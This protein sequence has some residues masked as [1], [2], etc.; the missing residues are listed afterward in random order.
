MVPC[1]GS[2]SASRSFR[3]AA[4]RGLP[5]LPLRPRVAVAHCPSSPSESSE[6]LQSRPRPRPR[7]RRC[8]C[9]SGSGSGSAPYEYS[10]SLSS[11]SHTNA[12]SSSIVTRPSLSRSIALKTAH[13]SRSFLESG[14][15][16][17]RPALRT[18]VSH[19]S[20]VRYWDRRPLSERRQK[21]PKSFRGSCPFSPRYLPTTD[22]NA[23]RCALGLA[24]DA[25]WCN[26]RPGFESRLELHHVGALHQR[27]QPDRLNRQ[28]LRTQRRAVRRA[29]PR[30]PRWP[31]PTALLLP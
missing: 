21:S 15:T 5:W 10:S 24:A 12:V 26:A 17:T 20:A 28:P 16:E 30:A 23:V 7:P 11:S 4:T 1:T 3:S 19:S 25:V 29:Q 8:S 9:G 2:P 27:R 6:S 22:T 14:G 13:M 31:R 18:I